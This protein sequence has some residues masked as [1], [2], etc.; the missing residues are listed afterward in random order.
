MIRMILEI[1]WEAL[2]SFVLVSCG[3]VF[4]VLVVRSLVFLVA[5]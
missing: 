5:A 4:A 3:V 1:I 2:V